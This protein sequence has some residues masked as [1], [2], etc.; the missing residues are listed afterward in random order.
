MAR[1]V[2]AGRARRISYRCGL[3]LFG[4]AIFVVLAEIALRLLPVHQGLYT[5]LVNS[6][7][8]I[9][10][11]E[12][13]R[14]YTWSHGWNFSIVNSVRTNNY[15]FVSNL[16][17]HP[18]EKT[19]LLAIVGDSFIEAA[20]VPWAQ[21]GAGRLATQIGTSGR[22]YSFGE[23]G[24]PMSQYLALSRYVRDTFHPNGLAILIIGNDFDCSWMKYYSEP[25]F[26]YFVE[27]P[28]GRLQLKRVDFQPGLVRRLRRHSAFARYLI[29]DAGLYQWYQ[30]LKGYSSMFDDHR[31]LTGHSQSAAERERIADSTRAID[32]FFSMLPGMSGLEKSDI[33]LLIDGTRPALYN[34][35]ALSEERG[36]YFDLMR[37]YFL[38]KGRSSG[39]H[40]KDLQPDFIQHY[41]LHHEKF[42]FADD[43]HWNGLGHEV[44]VNAV[45]GSELFKRLFEK[46]DSHS[47]EKSS[48]PK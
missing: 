43:D 32:A 10:K 22:V 14:S 38:E 18:H 47:H 12:P 7:N 48:P 44:F 21:T 36:T 41:H 4:L 23:G 28:N 8:P 1:S 39:F 9:L 27:D 19:P 25:G 31:V 11:Y 2:R 16:D 20:M 15:G 45:A 46:T 6:A 37:N 35:K 33:L 13:N 17:Y 42:E 5:Q 34:Q 40:V 3:I 29:L 24:A 26:H 30:G